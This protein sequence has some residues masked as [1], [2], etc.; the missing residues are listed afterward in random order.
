L[1]PGYSRGR[2]FSAELCGMRR[3]RGRTARRHSRALSFKLCG[4]AVF[5]LAL[6]FIPAV[7]L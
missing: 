4:G 2:L 6:H 1:C 3:W 5:R 7:K